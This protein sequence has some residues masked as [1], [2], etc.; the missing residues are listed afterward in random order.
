MADQAA[1][2]Q[3]YVVASMPTFEI[4]LA[5][6]YHYE[7]N[8]QIQYS[9]PACIYIIQSDKKY[10]IKNLWAENAKVPRFPQSLVAKILPVPQPTAVPAFWPEPVPPT[11]F[12]PRKF[13]KLFSKPHFL[14]ILTTF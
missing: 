11:E 3:S 10:W 13:Q 9:L 7:V 8:C 5:L 1:L 4:A 12:C 2:N 14:S 6:Y